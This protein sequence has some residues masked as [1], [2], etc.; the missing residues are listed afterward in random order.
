MYAVGVGWNVPLNELGTVRCRNGEVRP[1][2]RRYSDGGA[3]D[4]GLYSAPV[5]DLFPNSPAYQAELTKFGILAVKWAR[6]TWYTRDTFFNWHRYNGIAVQP[7]PGQDGSRARY[8]LRGFAIYIHAL[9][10]L[11]D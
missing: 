10:Q 2:E 1:T 4:V 11:E 7:E 5:F 3:Q 8:F 9:V 6:V